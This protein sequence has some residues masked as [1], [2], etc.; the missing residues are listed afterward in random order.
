MTTNKTDDEEEVFRLAIVP[1][2]PV[3]TQKSFYNSESCEIHSITPV[4]NSEQPEQVCKLLN[5]EQG[6]L[7]KR[8]VESSTIGLWLL[9]D[10]N[11]ASR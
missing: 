4:L 7:Q 6:N 11:L 5:N 1:G 3:L 9:A 10:N 8:T 2:F